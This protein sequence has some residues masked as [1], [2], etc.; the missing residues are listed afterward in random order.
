[1]PQTQFL[2]CAFKLHNPSRRRRNILDHALVE[3]TNT[4]AALLDWAKANLDQ[5]EAAARFEIHRGGNGQQPA[6][7]P[8]FSLDDLKQYLETPDILRVRYTDK[9][10]ARALPKPSQLPGDLASC[11]KEALAANVAAALASHL[12]L[13]LIDD[14]ASFPVCRDPDPQGYPNALEEFGSLG[15]NLAAE[16]EARARLLTVVRGGVMPVHFSRSRDFALLMQDDGSRFFVFLKLLPKDSPLAETTDITQGDLINVLTGEVFKYKG[17]SG[18]LF[19]IQLGRESNGEWGWQYKT[20]IAPLLDGQGAVKAAKLVKRD[21]DYF[22]H[23]S[24]A[25]ACP[26]PYEPQALMGF[27]RGVIHSLAYGVIDREGRI[28]A[29][30]HSEDPFREIKE[31]SLR[32]VR[33]KQRRAAR[34]S[35]KD[36]KRQELD[37]IIHYVVNQ[38]LDRAVDYQAA[39]VLE[40]WQVDA[41]GAFYRSA[42]R[43]ID[44]II[45]YKARLRGVPIFPRRMWSAY[46]SQLCPHCGG[47]LTH[48]GRKSTCDLC[49]QSEHRDE[50]AAI[51]CARRSLYKK[52]AWGGSKDKP[53]DWR[54][55]HQ[56]FNQEGFDVREKVLA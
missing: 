48:D 15:A 16:N 2:S 35:R 43:K 37:N 11:V 6:P 45:E 29:T 54:K 9:S 32:Q 51:N 12:A 46:I 27:N 44:Q 8:V 22:L 17:K 23:V 40:D 56:S 24:F 1:M 19:P 7:P 18:Y 21:N 34:V 31:R 3:Y 14:K 10:V 36:Y 4:M 42:F 47:P 13:R 20:F 55:F 5:I 26:D 49:G 41:V 52:E 28:L 50:L 53:G 38:A 25:L 30:G 33:E 39:L